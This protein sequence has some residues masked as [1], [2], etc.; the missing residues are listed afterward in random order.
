M[1][2]LVKIKELTKLIEIK[3]LGILVA[4]IKIEKLAKLLNIKKLIELIKFVKLEKLEKKEIYL[5]LLIRLELN[6]LK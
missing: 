5:L 6:K 1:V 2:E 4:L 3:K